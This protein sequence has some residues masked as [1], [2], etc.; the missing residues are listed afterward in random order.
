MTTKRIQ[1]KSRLACAYRRRLYAS[2]ISGVCP[3][4]PVITLLLLF[5]V[6]YAFIVTS[7]SKRTKF[8]M[9]IHSLFRA[10]NWLRCD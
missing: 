4:A 2:K 3:E 7:L 8:S 6:N 1:Q 5:A 10:R 9:L